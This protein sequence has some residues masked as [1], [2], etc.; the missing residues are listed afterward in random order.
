MSTAGSPP[1]F[2]ASL[3]HRTRILNGM[4]PAEACSVYESELTPFEKSEL[5]KFHYIYTVGSVRV[6]SRAQI[7]GYDS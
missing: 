6:K 2:G 3:Q 4:T 7:K 1:T 5:S